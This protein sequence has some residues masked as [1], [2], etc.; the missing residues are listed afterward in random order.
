M[1]GNR[2]CGLWGG[3]VQLRPNYQ[4]RPQL[5]AY[6]LPVGAISGA[7]TIMPGHYT[8]KAAAALV[9]I[10]VASMRNY[11]T[12]FADFLSA[13]AS[14]PA[15]QERKLHD[16]DIAVLQR[17]VELR[18]QGMATESIRQTLRDEDISALVPYVDAMPII[19]PQAPT[20]SPQ[21]ASLDIMG[22]DIILE[23]MRASE[24]RHSDLQ[25][26]YSEMQN[27]IEAIRAEQA[28]RFTWFVWGALFGILVV[29]IVL[30]ILWGGAMMR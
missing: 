27:Q 21:P 11:T 4:N 3:R 5:A 14:P 13:D 1:L 23:A 2:G 28:Q 10:S 19:E 30:A 16:H 17:A 25:A 29:L 7:T 18:A 12:I 6:L 15:G 22:A 9:G 26:R 24:S 20:E 8:T